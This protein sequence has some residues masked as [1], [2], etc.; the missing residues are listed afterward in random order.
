VRSLRARLLRFV[1][2][3]WARRIRWLAF[4]GRPLQLRFAMWMTTIV[5]R[6]VWRR[7]EPH[8]QARLRELLVRLAR[9]RTLPP[10]ERAEL[11]RLA[12]KL[13]GRLWRPAAPLAS[14]GQ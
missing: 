11:E 8:E 9:R 7:L 2:G 6:R 13:R 12:R 5:F 10:D 14:A 4:K 3:R 1:L